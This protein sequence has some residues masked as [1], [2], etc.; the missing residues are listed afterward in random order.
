[1]G[2]WGKNR[3]CLDGLSGEEGKVRG[4]SILGRVFFCGKGNGLVKEYWE[5]VVG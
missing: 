5:F 1:M 3:S 4:K 2:F